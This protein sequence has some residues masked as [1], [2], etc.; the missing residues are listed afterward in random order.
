VAAR[1]SAQVA[2]IVTLKPLRALPRRARASYEQGFDLRLVPHKILEPLRWPT[3]K[4]VFVNLDERF[5]SRRR[6]S[7]LYIAVAEVMRRHLAHL[8]SPDEAIITN[9]GT[10]SL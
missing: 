10:A 4:M 9:A 1:R 3:P 2:L 8:S 6:T 5:V 7:Q